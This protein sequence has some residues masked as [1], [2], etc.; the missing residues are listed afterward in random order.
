MA[1]TVIVVALFSL[2]SLTPGVSLLGSGGCC[3]WGRPSG[4]SPVLLCGS[5]PTIPCPECCP[6]KCCEREWASSLAVLLCTFWEFGPGFIIAAEFS[7]A[8]ELNNQ[9]EMNGNHN[10]EPFH[11][12]HIRACCRPGF[13]FG[14]CDLWH[15]IILFS[16]ILKMIKLN[17]SVGNTDSF[18]KDSIFGVFS[19]FLFICLF[20]KREQEQFVPIPKAIS[21]GIEFV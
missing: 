10:C 15:F 14:R 20:L 2:W 12:G 21:C 4:L 8:T 5:S 13:L 19:F 6:G 3:Q 18:Y 17:F 1:G 9:A 16:S 7:F 11:M